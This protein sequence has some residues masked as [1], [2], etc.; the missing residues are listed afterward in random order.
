MIEL[1]EEQRRAVLNGEPVEVAVPEIGKR[2]VLMRA[3]AFDEVWEIL[4]EERTRKGIAAVA[5]RNAAARA[6]EL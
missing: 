2:L 4:Q 6:E 1:T 3:D 5:A